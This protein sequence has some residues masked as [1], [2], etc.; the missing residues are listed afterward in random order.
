MVKKE[1]EPEGAVGSHRVAEG[2]AAFEV[3][4]FGMELAGGCARSK[5]E[6]FES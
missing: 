5:R 4:A 6:R 2:V 3:Q 1:F